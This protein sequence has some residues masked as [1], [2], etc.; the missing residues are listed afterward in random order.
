M[1]NNE[2]KLR[3]FKLSI[4]TFN[5]LISLSKKNRNNKSLTVEQLIDNAFN[6]KITSE[7]NEKK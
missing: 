5:K 4:E 3:G 1:E 6:E 7:L 2:T